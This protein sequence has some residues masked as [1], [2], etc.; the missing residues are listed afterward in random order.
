MSLSGAT[1]GAMTGAQIGAPFG[2]YGLLIGGAVGA[3]GGGLMTRKSEEERKLTDFYSQLGKG[4]SRKEAAMEK[5][6]AEQKADAAE[7]E[8]RA[9]LVARGGVSGAGGGVSGVSMTSYLQSLGLAQKAKTE[10]VGAQNKALADRDIQMRIAAA[11][12]MSAIAAQKALDKEKAM[13]MITDYDWGKLGT[14]AKAPGDTTGIQG[15]PAPT[16][17]G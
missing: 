2:A 5:S 7:S 9:T 15:A 12:G 8:R 4:V 14:G 13:G 10:A 17:V 11:Q 1:A 3:I 16:Q 6:I